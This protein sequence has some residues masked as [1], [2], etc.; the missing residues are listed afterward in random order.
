[1]CQV[2]DQKRIVRVD[3]GKRIFLLL[4]SSS[5]SLT[6]LNLI[7]AINSLFGFPS[8]STGT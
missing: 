2:H 3:W 8:A 5:Y 4:K 1:L 6:I 7:F